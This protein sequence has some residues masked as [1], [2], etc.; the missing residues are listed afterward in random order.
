[1]FTRGGDKG[2]SLCQMQIVIVL[3]EYKVEGDRTDTEGLFQRRN[4][5]QKTAYEMKDGLVGSEMCIRDSLQPYIPARQLRSASDTQSF[6]TPHVTVSY[7]HLT[8]PTNIAV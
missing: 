1:M 7:T 2:S 5:K 8:L 3:L 4:F 6:V